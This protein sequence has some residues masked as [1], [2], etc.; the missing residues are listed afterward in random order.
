MLLLIVLV[1]FAVFTLC[2]LL[3]VAGRSGVS[4]Q[5]EQTMTV[6]QAALAT[7][8]RVAVDQIV[9]IRK[10]ELFSAVP[11]LNRLLLRLEI[12]PRLRTLLYQ[13]DLQWTAGGLIV[14]PICCWQP[15]FN[16]AGNHTLSMRRRGDA[17]PRARQSTR[18]RTANKML[19]RGHLRIWFVV[20]AKC[21]W[22]S[23]NERYTV[24]VPLFFL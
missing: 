17:K 2:A 16:C 22:R 1:F 18:V 4:K 10:E 23:N 13:A 9:D 19:G 21:R 5:T 20:T 7:G 14:L 12:A 24:C 8:N 6:L 15:A 11:L 3:L